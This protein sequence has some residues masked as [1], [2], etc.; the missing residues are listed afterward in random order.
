[1]Q[2]TATSSDSSDDNASPRGKVGPYTLL[3]QVGEGG[4]GVV[5]LA[6]RREPFVQR[7]ALKL[8]KPGMDSRD[9]LA[10]FDQE[11]Q[12]LAVMDHP[13]VARVLDGGVTS[14][15][16]GSRPYFVM[17]Y[18][19]GEAITNY[20]DRNC[21]SLRERLSLMIP[22]CEAI[23]HAH[24][25]GI[26]HRDIKP[27]NVLVSIIEGR[28]TPKV[29]DF[30][31]AK[32]LTH[33]LTQQTL[34]T[35]QGKLIGTPE[36]MSPEQ[37]EMGATDI[38]TRT[39][40]Y[41]LGVLLYEL[42]SGTL[43]FERESLRGAAFD[44]V[45][46]IIREQEPPKPSTRLTTLD[47]VTATQL[48]HKR[49]VE[50]NVWTNTLRRELEWIPLKA[51]RKDR[52]RRYATPMALAEDIRNYLDDKP[53]DAAPESK[54]YLLRKLAAR[55]KGPMVATA[56]VLA[57]LTLGIIGMW[58]FASRAESLRV[59]AVEATKVAQAEREKAEQRSAEILAER[60]KQERLSHVMELFGKAYLEYASTAVDTEGE[61]ELEPGVEGSWDKL[62]QELDAGA[63]KYIPDSEIAIRTSLA[64]IVSTDGWINGEE[65][66]E[67]AI[68][69]VEQLEVALELAQQKFGRFAPATIDLLHKLAEA[70]VLAY[71]YSDNCEE[72]AD[73]AIVYFDEELV[74]LKESGATATALADRILDILDFVS[75]FDEYEPS[76]ETY[77]LLD[78]WPALVVNGAIPVPEGWEGRLASFVNECSAWADWYDPPSKFSDTKSEPG[79][80]KVWRD[81]AAKITAALPPP[82]K[83]QGEKTSQPN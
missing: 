11:R 19:K 63:L 71:E 77:D 72:C 49:Q 76:E 51:I 14:K 33:T 6:E 82:A 43:P 61:H 59:Q 20:C 27:S 75:D 40:V 73:H 8:I 4:F 12:A 74:A 70:N 28:P 41:S 38:D 42:L 60:A 47:N 58:I 18:V 36:Y 30:G 22:V 39:D 7:V 35:E 54:W 66:N 62:V 44:E 37:A 26:I 57:A 81:A 45:R 24:H 83:T 67:D 50:R 16:E 69:A 3:D 15:E 79:R 53:I 5:Y 1:M 68:I 64:A 10:R 46:R 31:V 48:A 9:V 34:F 55:N 78:K 32:A 29:I 23:Q 2:T 13:N 52:A 17:E 25:K 65:A 56:A 21:L 80:A